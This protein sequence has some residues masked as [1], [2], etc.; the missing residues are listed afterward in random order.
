MSTRNVSGGGLEIV[1]L[2]NYGDGR[3][4]GLLS[5][6]LSTSCMVSAVRCRDSGVVIYG[7]EWRCGGC[8]P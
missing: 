1:P 6:S 4:A 3:F 7:P 2:S 5:V 8:C